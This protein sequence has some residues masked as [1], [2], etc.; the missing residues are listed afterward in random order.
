MMDKEPCMQV[1]L[2]IRST[3]V[4]RTTRKKGKFL[5]SSRLSRNIVF[6]YITTDIIT[7]SACGCVC[8]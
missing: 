3:I 2:Y 7:L 4:T 1:A 6:S 8:V 5:M